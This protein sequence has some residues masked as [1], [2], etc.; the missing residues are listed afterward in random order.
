MP[1][2]E[3][4]E[5]LYCETSYVLV[6]IP[7]GLFWELVVQHVGQ[8]SKDLGFDTTYFNPK[9]PTSD[10]NP[11][12]DKV[13]KIALGSKLPDNLKILPEILSFFQYHG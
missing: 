10:H 1:W 2:L 5:T 8:W 6:V 9:N 7:Y 4:V 11:S 13:P 3:I 12:P